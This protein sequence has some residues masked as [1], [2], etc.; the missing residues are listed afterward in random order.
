MIVY[1]LIMFFITFFMMACTG[2]QATYARRDEFWNMDATSYYLNE[3]LRLADPVFVPTE[4]P[5]VH[6]MYF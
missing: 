2:I 3:V 4:V 6:H 1:F 5:Y